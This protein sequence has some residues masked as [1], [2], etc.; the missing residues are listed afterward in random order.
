MKRAVKRALV[1]VSDKS[2]LIEFVGRLVAAGVEVVSSG[3][4]A[5]T[6][7][8]AGLPVTTVAEVTGAPEMLGGRV[9]TL[10]P[11]IHG[12]ILAD[13]S[14]SDH[15]DDLIEH[16]IAPFEL[17]VVNL[18]PFESTV[19]RDGVTPEEAIENIDIGG[20]TLIRS[21]AKNYRWVGVVTS[22][23]QYEAV[24]TAI[25]G[26]GL[27]IELREALAKE[28]FYSTASYD[29][30]I[31][32]WLHRDESL[33]E[34]VVVALSK[35]ESLRYG[36]NPEQ[37]AALYEQRTGVGSWW[38]DATQLQGKPMS[39]NNYLDTDAAWRLV[40]DLGFVGVA[41]IKHTNAA[42]AA[43]R[44][45]L[46]A[47]FA[48]AWAC[49]PLA[50]FGGIVA[51]N[52]EVDASTAE[53]ITQYF[54]EVVIAPSVSDDA[55][56]IFAAKANL[57]VLVAPPPGRGGLE[58][59]HIERGALIQEYPPVPL[60]VGN[61]WDDAWETVSARKPTA[62]EQADLAFAWVVAAHTKSNAI[63]IAVEEAAV[64]VGAGDQSRVGAAQ[65][66]IDK[67][68]ERTNGAVAASDAFFPFRDGI[69]ALAAA[70]ITAIIEP[71]GS[72]RDDEVI[73]AA[74]EHGIGLVFTSRRY[75]KH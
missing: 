1:S 18:Y 12:G 64:G 66:A 75:F 62:E 17:V 36:E 61:R 14:Q 31:T 30:A 28:A 73:A 3:G 46:S 38:T 35:V 74:D 68:G 40:N 29:A 54:V 26:G 5:R 70:G 60:A 37:S 23:S 16:D 71:G 45:D 55:A 13:H 59:R 11:R 53:A 49:D 63:V 9:K 52:V 72:M 4:T 22:P 20:P 57:R 19:A 58:M 47:A 51:A 48:A 21:A 65:R 32:D 25:E 69:D 8:E 27:D 10:H 42:G 15:T 67:A 34:R 39:F 33:P 24:A 43:V 41:V 50:A 56:A 44:E 2:G 7:S 6:I